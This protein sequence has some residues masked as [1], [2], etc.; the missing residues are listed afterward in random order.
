MKFKYFSTS[1]KD[2]F[3]YLNSIKFD[4][5]E[6]RFVYDNTGNDVFNPCGTEQK[7]TKYDLTIQTNQGGKILV[8]KQHRN[9]NDWDFSEKLKEKYTKWIVDY[10]VKNQKSI[11]N[12]T[13]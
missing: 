5:K 7:Q 4:C 6:F 3:H 10:S 13:K 8:L 1:K 11:N 12:L 9:C 2:L